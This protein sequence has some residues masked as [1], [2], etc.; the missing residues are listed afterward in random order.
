MPILQDAEVKMKL[1]PKENNPFTPCHLI[2][3]F[4]TLFVMIP[5]ASLYA[6]PSPATGEYKI[7]LGDIIEVQV[8][9]EPDLSRSPVP[10]RIDGRISLPLL[11]DIAVA[12]KSINELAENLEKKFSSVINEPSVSIMLI[13]SRSLRYYLVGQIS[14]PGEFTLDHPITI[15]QA[16]A[17]GGGF[18]EWAKKSDILVVRRKSGKEQMLSFNYDALVKGKN[19]KQ[20]ILIAPG[21]TI[22][23]P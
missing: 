5:D 21:D 3:I 14:Q 16:I 17:R 23:V 19:L 2:Y 1:Y 20:N 15:L 7:G 12:G 11:G 4:L 9:K 8:W 13:E 18:L 10:V 6:Q 22:I